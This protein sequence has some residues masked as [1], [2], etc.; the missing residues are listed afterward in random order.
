MALVTKVEQLL[1]VFISAYRR[2][3]CTVHRRVNE[4]L[5]HFI[6]AKANDFEIVTSISDTNFINHCFSQNFSKLFS[7]PIQFKSVLLFIS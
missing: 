7:H 3:E 2:F 4:V 1:N 5:A 6:A